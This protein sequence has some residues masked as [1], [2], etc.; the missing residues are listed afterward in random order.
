MLWGIPWSW[1]G[2]S[3]GTLWSGNYALDTKF[4]QAQFS[5]RQNKFHMCL[6]P[7]PS[8]IRNNIYMTHPE[9]WQEDRIRCFINASLGKF[10]WQN[11]G[12]SKIGLW[13]GTLPRS[14]P[15]P[16]VSPLGPALLWFVLPEGRGD[17]PPIY[18]RPVF[19][20]PG[21]HPCISL[22]PGPSPRFLTRFVSF[23]AALKIPWVTRG[24][25]G[26]S[27]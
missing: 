5:Y 15:F 17:A 21:P 27:L 12:S 20:G 18:P 9:P 16:W 26:L 22:A 4:P 6:S 7:D 24:S 13:E 8:R 23:P 10:F 19:M 2:I 14:C 3:E 25:P 11:K 1:V